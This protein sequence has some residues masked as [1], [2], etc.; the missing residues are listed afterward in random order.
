MIIVTKTET[1]ETNI[2]TILR[3]VKHLVVSLVYEELFLEC[4]VS[5]LSNCK[6]TDG[7]V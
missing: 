1:L 5:F 7:I 2:H 6:Y 4:F 3:K